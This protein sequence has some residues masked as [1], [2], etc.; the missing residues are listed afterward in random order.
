MGWLVVLTRV[1]C[2]ALVKATQASV[3]GPGDLASPLERRVLTGRRRRGSLTGAG[4]GEQF[5]G[6]ELAVSLL[7][8]HGRRRD[9]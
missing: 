7:A 8:S 1:G 2:A 6:I 9:A 5:P 3:S 4:I